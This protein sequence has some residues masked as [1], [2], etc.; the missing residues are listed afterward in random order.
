[1]ERKMNEF[2]LTFGG[3]NY[4]DVHSFTDSLLLVNDMLL[5][6]NKELGTN[7]KVELTV[8]AY[9]DCCFDI[10]L[11]LIADAVEVGKSIDILK[12]GTSLVVACEIIK[13]FT[14]F[15]NLKKHLKG[16]KPKKVV[17]I[18]GGNYKITNENGDTHIY[19]APVYNISVNNHNANEKLDKLFDGIN[20]TPS[21]ESITIKDNKKENMF[22]AKKDDGDFKIMLDDNPLLDKEDGKTRDKDKKNAILTVYNII[23]DDTRQWEFFYKGNRIPVKLKAVKFIDDV[24]SRKQALLNGDKLK[25]DLVIYQKYNEIAKVWENKK[26]SI[27]EV[28]DVITPEQQEKLNLDD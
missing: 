21:I 13:T 11:Q 17:E 6:I 18:N 24:L 5:E 9:D 8:K 10:Y 22:E 3:K 12:D 15:L 23:F 20:K 2:N 16:K 19:N 25:C 7:K 14:S 26:Y 1:M 27:V 28:H 4:L